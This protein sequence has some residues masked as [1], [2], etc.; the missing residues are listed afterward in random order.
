MTAED[1]GPICFVENSSIDIERI[2]ES[3]GGPPEFKASLREASVLL[4]PSVLPE[5]DVPPAF[6]ESTPYILGRLKHDLG[7][8]VTVDAAI[9]DD[10]YAEFHYLSA[11]A[12][13]PVIYIA[14]NVLL[15]F[16][17]ST[18]GSYVAGVAGQL[19]RDSANATQ[20]TVKGEIRFKGKNG[21]GFSLK[22]EGPADTYEQLNLQQ[23]RELGALLD[24]EKPKKPE[25]QDES[26]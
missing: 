17:V 15:P 11:D 26:A 12:Y 16:V 6:P 5:E 18:I 4:L 10:N 21:E 24:I 8:Q 9:H 2:I 22:Y 13:L 23:I 19:K 1:T 14:Q 7:E 20:N 25:K 3:A